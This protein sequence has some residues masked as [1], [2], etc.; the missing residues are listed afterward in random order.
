MSRTDPSGSLGAILALAVVLA[1]L[2]FAATDADPGPAQT[3]VR[4]PCAHVASADVP[5][6]PAAKRTRAAALRTCQQR[7][8]P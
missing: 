2:A 1:F 7:T 6:E 4:A 8:T 3:T 5:T